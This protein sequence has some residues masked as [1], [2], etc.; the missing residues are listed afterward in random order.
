MSGLLDARLGSLI[1]LA[2]FLEGGLVSVVPVCHQPL[3]HDGKVVFDSN[4]APKIVVLR[5]VHLLWK[6]ARVD[7]HFGTTG[8]RRGQY[9]GASQQFRAQCSRFAGALSRLLRVKKF[10]FSVYVVQVGAHQ[11][12]LGMVFQVRDLH[13]KPPGIRNVIRIKEGDV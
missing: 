12:N 6:T 13:F 7:Q 1:R 9:A 3:R 5:V 4:T 11:R 2:D 10:T 8:C